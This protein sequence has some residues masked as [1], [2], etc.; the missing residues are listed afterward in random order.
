MNSTSNDAV[1]VTSNGSVKATAVCVGG[2]YRTSSNGSITPIPEIGCAPIADPL[3][4]LPEPSGGPCISDFVVKANETRTIDPG[5]YC[6]K[7]EVSSNGTLKMRP[8]LYIFP[9]SV[10]NITSNAKVLAEEVTLFFSGKTGTLNIVS[11]G[12][13]QI[14]APKTGTYQGIAI[15]QSRNKNTL[16]SSPHDLSSNSSSYI[17]GAI[18]APNGH[19]KFSSNSN[20]NTKASYTFMIARRLD[21]TS[22]GKLNLKLT[23]DGATPLP[24]LL[25]TMASDTVTRLVR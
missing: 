23:S 22:N 5:T 7:L 19:F 17:E 11:N 4:T 10:F 16:E 18:Y 15:F 20:M 2:R 6:K 21:L 8:G 24:P 25:K 9:D 13:F 14:T 12:Q 1:S 3:A